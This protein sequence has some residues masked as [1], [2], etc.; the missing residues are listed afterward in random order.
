MEAL[1]NH[2]L[3]ETSEK[4]A[5]ALLI[6]VES[7]SPA[8]E[9]LGELR[10][11]PE[12]KAWDDGKEKPPEHGLAACGEKNGVY[13]PA[14]QSSQPGRCPGASPQE[15]HV[16]RSLKLLHSDLCHCVSFYPSYLELPPLEKLITLVAISHNSEM[17]LFLYI[18]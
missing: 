12:E 8:T 1:D 2:M 15:P 3:G 16:V 17:Y 4:P 11:L 13:P 18:I 6:P 10:E 9:S 5:T 7:W 14:R